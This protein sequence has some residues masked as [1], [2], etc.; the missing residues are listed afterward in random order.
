[1]A[2]SDPPVAW[3]AVYRRRWALRHKWAWRIYTPNGVQ[4]SGG[5]ARTYERAKASG[6]HAAKHG[7]DRYVPTLPDPVIYSEGHP[8]MNFIPWHGVV[9]P[10]RA[11]THN[12]GT[13]DG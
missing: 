7:P 3:L 13:S 8:D 4:W 5:I 6:E 1:M 12:D 10:G 11:H 9:G 2:R